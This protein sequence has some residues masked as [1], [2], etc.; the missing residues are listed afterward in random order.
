MKNFDSKLFDKYLQGKCSKEEEIEVQQWLST[1]EGE[2]YV[3]Q[4][5]D[6]DIESL[7]TEPEQLKDYPI[8]S[9]RIFKNIL[10]GKERLSQEVFKQDYSSSLRTPTRSINQYWQQIAA[11]VAGIILI[12][13]AYWMLNNR[14]LVVQE[15]AFGETKNIIL[16]DGSTVMMNGNSSI[17]YKAD[18]KSGKPREVWLKGEAFFS[19]VHTAD[20]QRFF[21]NTSDQFNIEVLGTTFNVLKRQGKTKVTLNTGKVRLNMK[22]SKDSPLVEMK[23]GELVEFD[24]ASN[25]Y[26]KK[27]VNPEAYS[28]WKSRKMVFEQT[29]LADIIL[30][31]EETYGLTVEVKDRSLLKHTFNGTVPT[32]NV[33]ILLEG[34][35]QL[36]DLQITK[37]NTHIKI[38]SK[39]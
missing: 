39:Q 34:L 28:S 1:P 25:Q 13:F 32:D 19:I 26:T 36:F 23:P 29:S 12:A 38:K 16:P 4:Q 2:K 35:S 6:A 18:W 9:Q 11:A 14:N 24:D 37:Q 10:A 20:H 3:L 22:E 5:M 15:T 27:S 33:D 17:T 8:D 30:L 7:S 21:V 31:L